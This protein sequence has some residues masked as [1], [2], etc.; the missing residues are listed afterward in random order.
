MIC[1][2]PSHHPPVLLFVV[3]AGL[4]GLNGAEVSSRCGHG[5][6]L[7]PPVMPAGTLRGRDP[8]SDL[9]VWGFPSTIPSSLRTR[10]R[11][12]GRGSSELIAP[13]PGIGD[14]ADASRRTRHETGYRCA[15]TS[16][17]CSLCSTW[18]RAL[19]RYRS[20]FA[21]TVGVA[22]ADAGADAG[23]NANLSSEGVREGGF[24]GAWGPCIY[25]RDRSHTGRVGI[26]G[27]PSRGA[28]QAQ[29][30]GPVT[31]AVAYGPC[32]GCRDLAF[33]TV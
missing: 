21:N 27:H 31:G 8:R 11:G 13:D 3:S 28:R 32:L 26:K 7:K 18:T 33:C 5:D 20:R 24:P 2:V 25:R 29:Q 14:C 17:R 4:Q 1:P 30:S 19:G 12:G 9:C 10:R 22:V 6:A 23:A 16:R 15:V